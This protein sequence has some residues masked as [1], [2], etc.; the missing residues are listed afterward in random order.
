[1]RIVATFKSTIFKFPAEDIRE[2]TESPGKD[3]AIWLAARLRALDSGVVAD[4]EPED[5]GWYITFSTEEVRYQAVIGPIGDEFWYVVVERVVGFLPS[6]L[7]FRRKHKTPQGLLFVHKALK[8]AEE[9][10]QLQWHS[11]K[12][13]SKGGA[14]AFDDGM[15]MPVKGVQA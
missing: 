3:V 4:P 5:F 14:S 2:L 9:T 7:G 15:E 1:M 10:S 13:F 6:I 8:D 12:S 11:W